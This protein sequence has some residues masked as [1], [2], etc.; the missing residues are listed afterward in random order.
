MRTFD[1]TEQVPFS[2]SSPISSPVGSHQPVAA[3]G[4]NVQV[5][6]DKQFLAMGRDA[7]LLQLQPAGEA[8]GWGRTN[9]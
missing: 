6:V 7:E 3:A 8:S 2:H 5:G 1:R 4:N 9:T